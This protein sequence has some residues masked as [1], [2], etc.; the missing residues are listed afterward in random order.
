MRTVSTLLLTSL[1]ACASSGSGSTLTP[2]PQ[3]IQ[4]AGSPSGGTMAMGGGDASTSHVIAFAPDQVWRALPA[5]F[6]S[7]GIPIG[8]LDAAK[9]TMG[10]SGFK[11]RGR[12]RNTPLSRLID[13]GNSTQVGPNAD[14]YDVNLTLLAEV[15]PGEAGSSNVNLAFQAMARP[16]TFAQEYSQCGSKAVLETRFVDI[17]NAKLRR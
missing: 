7:L 15:R 10:N 2:A 3:S 16:A 11:V 5:V 4:I 8:T 14:S 12:L 9:R 13:C 17:L 6:D 1:A